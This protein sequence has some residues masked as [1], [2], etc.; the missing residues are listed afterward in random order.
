MRVNG[1]GSARRHNKMGAARTMVAEPISGRHQRTQSRMERILR[2][3]SLP[4][5]CHTRHG[6][7]ASLRSSI[8][9]FGL[10]QWRTA[11]TMSIYTAF[12]ATMRSCCMSEVDNLNTFP[13]NLID[14]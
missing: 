14:G 1:T 9:S 5:F 3:R 6:V 11:L 8:Q 4:Y 13:K 7:L 12:M 2:L 10:P